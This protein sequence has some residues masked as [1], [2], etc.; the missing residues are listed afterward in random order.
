MSYQHLYVSKEWIVSF[1]ARR[2]YRIASIF[3]VGFIAVILTFVFAEDA[4]HESPILAL[5]FRPAL[6]TCLTGAVLTSAA[7]EYF[8]F[9]YDDLSRWNRVF[10][11]FVLCLF[12]VG[13]P[14]YCYKVY[15]RSKYFR[16]PS[17]TSSETP[18]RISEGANTG[19]R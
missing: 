11:F 10:W 6:F 5:L 8:Y 2:V 1:T 14:L 19:E 13:A 3:S 9:G 12:P 18:W 16:V 17:S 15:S 4:L 7:M